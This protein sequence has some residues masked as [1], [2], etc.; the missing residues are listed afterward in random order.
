MLR[1]EVAKDSELCEKAKQAT[2]WIGYQCGNNPHRH[3]CARLKD[4]KTDNLVLL[5]VRNANNTKGM[6]TGDWEASYQLGALAS[7]Q[8][9][10]I[11]D[12][13]F[14]LHLVMWEP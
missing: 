6:L 3:R 11:D 8:V 7:R 5:D 12:T 10:N 14:V 1:I 13:M 9:D 4:A 2:P